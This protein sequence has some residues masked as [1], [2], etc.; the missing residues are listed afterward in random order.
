MKLQ[1]YSNYYGRTGWYIGD[2]WWSQTKADDSTYNGCKIYLKKTEKKLT[3]LQNAVKQ[4]I[5]DTANKSPDSKIGITAFSSA[6]YGSHG[7]TEDLQKAGDN[8]EN[9]QGL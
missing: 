6:G 3:A 1:Y 9:R 4:F 5:T 7:K 2:D 8:K